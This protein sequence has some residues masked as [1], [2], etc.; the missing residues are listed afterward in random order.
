MA[1]E[2]EFYWLDQQRD[3]NGRPSRHGMNLAA[4]AIL[5]GIYRGIRE[6]LDPAPNA[7][8]F[9]LM[10]RSQLIVGFFFTKN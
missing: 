10:P 6:Q 3:S 9:G 4:A 8:S 5:A 1:A 7:K 2:L